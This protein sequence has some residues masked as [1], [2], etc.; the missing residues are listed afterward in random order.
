MLQNLEIHKEPS[1]SVSVLPVF[2]AIAHWVSASN[3]GPPELVTPRGPG[4]QLVQLSDPDVP[5]ADRLARVSVCLQ[6]DGSSI[7]LLVKR[8]PDVKSLALYLEM[9]FDQN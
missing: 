4:V 7:V 8:L 3:E 5:K 2:Y 1:L 9:V 6:L